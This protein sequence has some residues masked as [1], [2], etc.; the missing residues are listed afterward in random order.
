[1]TTILSSQPAQDSPRLSPH[2]TIRALHVYATLD[3]G[4]AETWLMD[5]V[6]KCPREELAIDVC[7]TSGRIGAYEDE[8]RSLGGAIHRCRMSRNPF[9]FQRRFQDILARQTYDVVHS[10]L[11][12]FSGVVLW[13]AALSGVRQRVAHNHPVEDL[14]RGGL[15]RAAYAGLMRR[16]MCRYGT[17][18]VGPT[19]A[20]LESF[21]GSG[22]ESDPHKRVLYNGIDV[23]RFLQPAERNAV[24]KE[25]IL[26][27]DAK[28]ILNVGRFVSHKRQG[29]LID[30]A[31]LL[32]P[33]RNDAYF[34][35][36]GDGPMREEVEQR[37]SHEGLGDRFRLI[38][39]QPNIDR[40]WLASDI[41]AFPSINEGFGI[42]VAE[43]A[44]AGLPVVACNIP[45]LREAA[46]AC[47]RPA[48]LPLDA[49]PQEW[50]ETIVAAISR[51]PLDLADRR[52]VA[53]T[54]PFTIESSIRSLKE[55]YGLHRE[56]AT[57]YDD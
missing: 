21:W 32:V 36:I 35:M 41:F 31:K 43:A 45:G 20:S 27:D 52:R 26:P 57:R 46:R 17:D 22:W 11:Y 15:L 48:L 8:F 54:F 2:G 12:Y 19:R 13:A 33:V 23:S 3:R 34:L 30:V 38:R 55:L 24:R 44:A 25:L 1:M 28:I 39:G 4:G 9:A 53:A 14:K 56:G 51:P 18:F 37:F 50:S 16:W 29:F 10:H 5:V 42:V 40:Y 6:R 47:D 49:T 7:V